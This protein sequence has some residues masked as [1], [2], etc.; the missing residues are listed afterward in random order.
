MNRILKRNRHGE[1]ENMN[2]DYLEKLENSYIKFEDKLK[3]KLSDKYLIIVD[4]NN[5]TI[6]EVFL[7]C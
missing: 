6:D 5:R 4:T 7:E 1:A 3:G 2:K